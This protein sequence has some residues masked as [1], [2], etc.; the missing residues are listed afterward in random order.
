MTVA[1]KQ[2]Q[3]LEDFLVIED[4]QERLTA[5]VERAR[6][7]APLPD[8]A[9]VD[10]HRVPGC[11]SRVWLTAE[12]QGDALRFRFD[13]ESPMVKG[14][15]GL[16]VELYDGGTPADIVATDTTLLDDLGLLRDLTP[17]RRSGLAG[18]RARIKA[19]ALAHLSAST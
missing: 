9:K 6:S 1:E 13:A 15:I 8:S 14:L 12:L 16:I 11:Q 4:R 18:V 19:L 3:L 17:T 5:V 2:R 7:T 10:A